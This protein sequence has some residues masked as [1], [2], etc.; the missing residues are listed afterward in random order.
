MQTDIVALE[1]KPWLN[2]LF[3]P[4]LFPY[5]WQMPEIYRLAHGMTFKNLHHVMYMKHYMQVLSTFLLQ[6]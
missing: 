1:F 6:N 3:F 5:F 4:L 2:L